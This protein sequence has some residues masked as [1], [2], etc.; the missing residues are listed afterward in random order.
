MN[1][2]IPEELKEIASFRNSWIGGQMIQEFASPF[3]RLFMTMTRQGRLV[4]LMAS[5]WAE[6]RKTAAEQAGKSYRYVALL[7][8]GTPQH[9]AA[10]RELGLIN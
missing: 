1:G 2:D 7:T 3:N 6:A 8:P 9:R 5:S 10:E 4:Y